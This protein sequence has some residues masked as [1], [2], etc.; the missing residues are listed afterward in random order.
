MNFIEI[1]PALFAP[2]KEMQ[3]ELHFM[4]IDTASSRDSLF[5]IRFALAYGTAFANRLAHDLGRDLSML[6][7]WI[8]KQRPDQARNSSEISQT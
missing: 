8:A 1:P 2:K 5:F 7:E 3:V 6:R 4:S